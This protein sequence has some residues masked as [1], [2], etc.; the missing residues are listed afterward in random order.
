MGSSTKY[1]VRNAEGVLAEGVTKRA[2]AVEVADANRGA[3]AVEVVTAAGKVVHTVPAVR[4][5]NMS[6]PYTRVVTLPEGVEIPEGFRVCY[7][8]PRRKVA[9]LHSFEEG[10]RILNLKTGKL[11]K[12]VFETT[13]D[14]GKA[15]LAL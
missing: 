2:K 10:Y 4:K 13:R 12:P 7:S 9:V 6:K 3:S 14:A 5:I 11:L 1:T 8:R 15:M